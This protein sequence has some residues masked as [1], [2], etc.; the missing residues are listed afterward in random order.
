MIKI[1]NHNIVGERLHNLDFIFKY[2]IN[3]L[4]IIRAIG[5]EKSRGKLLWKRAVVD[6][7]EK[8]TIMLKAKKK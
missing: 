3:M 2:P 6:P 5:S 4:K 1:I 7:D 8:V